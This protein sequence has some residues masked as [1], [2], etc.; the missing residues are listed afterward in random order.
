MFAMASLAY[1]LAFLLVL[2]LVEQPVLA[3]LAYDHSVEDADLRRVHQ[4]EATY[5]SMNGPYLLLPGILAATICTGLQAWNSNA[6]IIPLA[7]FLV[8]LFTLGFI[9]FRVGAGAKAVATTEFDAPVEEIATSLR[10][11]VALHYRSLALVGAAFLGQLTWVVL[12]TLS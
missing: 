4:T 5:V 10:L 8:T 6:A 12:S 2:W 3:I 7:I 9:L 1:S 11:L